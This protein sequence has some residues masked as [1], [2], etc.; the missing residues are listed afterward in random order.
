VIGGGNVAIDSARVALRLGAKEAPNQ[1]KLGSGQV[2]LIYRRSE[3]EMPA[4]KAEIRHAK[5]EGIK[6]KFLTQPVK[7]KTDKESHVKTLECIKMKLGKPDESGRRSPIPMKNSNFFIPLDT[8][9]IAIGQNPN[10][11]IPSYTPGLKTRE[12][13]TIVIDE[14]GATS[15]E[16]VFAGGDIVTG[17]ATVIE[18]M[19]AGRKAAKAMDKYVHPVRDKT[20]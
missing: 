15:I 6:F 11:L 7:I 16:G 2:Y 12:D 5:E 18:A 8:L 20:S 3:E 13:G 14:K 1:S 17:A 10:P 19:G 9:V 4:R